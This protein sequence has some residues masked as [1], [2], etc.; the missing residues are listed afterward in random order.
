M[1]EA[2]PNR[3]LC[4]FFRLLRAGLGQLHA[5]EGVLR[6]VEDDLHLGKG[7]LQAGKAGGKIGGQG[8]D[9][10]A[11][12]EIAAARILAEIRQLGIDPPG[13]DSGVALGLLGAAVGG[14]LLFGERGLLRGG[15][16]GLGGRFFLDGAGFRCGLRLGCGFGAGGL[17][18]L[19]LVGEV[20]ALLRQRI[21]LLG[22]RVVVGLHLDQPGLQTGQLRLQLRVFRRE[23]VALVGQLAQRLLM[24]HG[25][26][27]NII[28][29]VGAVKPADRRAE[30][31]KISH[32][33]LLPFSDFF[34]VYHEKR[35]K[36][37]ENVAARAQARRFHDLFTDTGVLACG[38]SLYDCRRAKR[39][40]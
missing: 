37:T 25:G 2:G 36:T 5:V 15:L 1:G 39:L 6:V 16:R 14:Q 40:L 38:F 3:T 7:V 20:G 18:G 11:G 34:T 10:L 9:L 23:L 26:G 30:L 31:R 21:D 28:D 17:G 8:G 19:E 4:L 35:R 12:V 13:A 33:L 24:L 32:S 22:Q 27:F 29:N